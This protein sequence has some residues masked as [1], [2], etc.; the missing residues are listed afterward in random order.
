MKAIPFPPSTGY[1]MRL[2]GQGSRTTY[3]KLVWW[4]DDPQSKNEID[5]GVGT[6]PSEGLIMLEI[7]AKLYRFFFRCTELILHDF[8]LSASAIT[9]LAIS[10]KPAISTDSGLIFLAPSEWLSITK[11]N[12]E[13]AYHLPQ[14]FP[15]QLLRKL[16]TP[17]F[18]E[19]ED[20]FWALREEDPFQ[21]QQALKESYRR[22]IEAPCKTFQKIGRVPGEEGSLPIRCACECLVDKSC[23]NLILWHALL[24]DL[25][26][27]SK[28]AP[29][30]DSH[31]RLLETLPS[32]YIDAFTNLRALVNSVKNYV[33]DDFFRAMICCPEFLSFHAVEPRGGTGYIRFR[34]L[35]PSMK[36]LPQIFKFFSIS[37]TMKDQ[38]QWGA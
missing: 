15:L 23:R 5:C 37:M 12:A 7:Q 29:D 31:V 3:G 21:F 13:A 17:K 11:L 10:P 2:S 22:E 35:D 25:D 6:H 27:L 32:A 30:L 38:R 18:E 28:L 8:D 14:K 1:T 19:A 26:E 34:L 4:E 9:S 36:D 16:A 24:K 20:A 33:L